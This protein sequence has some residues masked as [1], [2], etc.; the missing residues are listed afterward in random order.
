MLSCSAI[1][2]CGG[3]TDLGVGVS[4]T[5]GAVHVCDGSPGVRLAARVGGGGPSEPGREMLAENGWE[6]LIV[7]GACEAWVLPDVSQPLHHL[8]LSSEQESALVGDLRV[9][10]WSALAARTPPGGG[11]ADASSLTYR[12]DQVRYESPGCGIDPQDE[13][14]LV[15]AALDPKVQQLAGL[16]AAADGDVRYLL[17]EG[18]ASAGSDSFYENPATW[19]LG[20]APATAALTR[21]QSFSQP[22]VGRSLLAS[23]DDARG[24]RALRGD[25]LA[26]LVGN[27]MY[28]GFIPIVTADGTRF[29]LYV[30]DASPFEGADGLIGPGVF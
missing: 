6:Y 27:M 5:T 7:T 12:F 25:F 14:A 18:D 26:G 2:A 16:G 30:R 15:D 8:T 24:L 1:A 28:A 10:R 19:P 17:I 23:G 29:E 13:F 22:T 3:S 9:G 20:V 11:C 4:S 21:A